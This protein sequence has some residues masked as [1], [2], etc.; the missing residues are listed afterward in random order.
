MGLSLSASLAVLGVTFLLITQLFSSTINEELADVGEAYKEMVNRA[1]DQCQ[2]SINITQIVDV[3]WWDTSWNYRKMIIIDHNQVTKGLID[4]PVLISRESDS[5]LAAEAQSSGH[6][7]VFI[8]EDNTKRY[9]HEIESYN[10]TTGKLTA[11]VKIPHLS[12]NVDTVLFMYYGNAVCGDQQNISGTWDENYMMVHHL[13]ETAGTVYDST[14]Y[15]NDATNNGAVYNSSAKIDGGYDFA[16]SG[17][18]NCGNDNSLDI[19]DALTLEAWV[20]DP[21][22]FKKPATYPVTIVNKQ[23]EQCTITPG[24]AF[25]VRR[26]ISGHV[27]SEVVF[28]ALCSPGI[29]MKEMVAGEASIYD[30]QYDA[31]A[32]HTTKEQSIEQIRTRLPSSLQAL[33]ALVYSKSFILREQATTIEMTFEPEDTINAIHS[34]RISYLA[35]DSHG[36]Y[37]FESTT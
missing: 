36:N 26:T 8:S 32:P 6:D 5:N 4:F 10:A 22:L 25:T 17:N 7:I 29:V 11:W 12:A 37:D 2:T 9:N 15:G 13:N 14:S 34:G 28:V 19:T 33:P 18:I 1:A 16:D 20:K 3:G 21:P 35:F 27:G 24:Q 23:E 31:H 30:T